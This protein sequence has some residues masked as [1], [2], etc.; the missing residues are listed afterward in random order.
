[1][2]FRQFRMQKF[3][4]NLDVNLD[5]IRTVEFTDG[6]WPGAGQAANPPVITPKVCPP[7]CLCRHTCSASTTVSTV[8]EPFRS[9]GSLKRFQRGVLRGEVLYSVFINRVWRL[10]DRG[11]MTL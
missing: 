11:S 10:P 7:L 1:M 5:K 3:R 8:L 9:G 4:Q 6:S 2:K